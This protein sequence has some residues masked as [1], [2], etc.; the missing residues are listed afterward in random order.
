MQSPNYW[1]GERIRL[2]AVEPEDAS[3]F[4]A[5]NRDDPAMSRN[6]DWVW[7]PTSIAQQRQWAQAESMKRM[8]NDQLF[9]VI[10]NQDGDLVGSINTHHCDRR[11]GNFSYGVA[12][13]PEFR[14]QGYAS[15]AIR[16]VMA[17]FFRE[18]RY[19]KV[20][21]DVYS[22]N[23]ASIHLHQ[24]LGFTQ[25]GRLRRTLFT[26]GA[27]YDLLIFG[28]TVEEFEEKGIGDW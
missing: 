14:G 26:N 9:L 8:E 24:K 11:V 23:D 6:L 2:R 21:V 25:E 1:Q 28:M 16:C 22:F 5:W 27:H 19:Q 10:E 13:R 15:E 7:P 17:Y 20:T 12:I 4:H 18:L 3:I